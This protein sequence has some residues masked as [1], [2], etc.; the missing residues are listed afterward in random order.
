MRYV[1]LG[2]WAEGPTDHPFLQPLL[3]RLVVEHVLSGQKSVEIS[4]E[5]IRLPDLKPKASRP[6]RICAAVSKCRDEISLLFIHS[7]GKGNPDGARTHV[8][9]PAIAQIASLQSAVHCVA[10]VPVHETE[11]WVLADSGALASAMGVNP[12]SFAPLPAA[13][14]V[15]RYP[16]P[17]QAVLERYQGVSAPWQSPDARLGPAADWRGDSVR[18]ASASSVV[19]SPG[20]RLAGDVESHATAVTGSTNVMAYSPSSR[21]NWSASSSYPYSSAY[22]PQAMAARSVASA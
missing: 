1:T 22:R 4:E 8:V 7:D 17:W 11:A 5:F 18:K 9:N 15:E 16:D 13:G 6:E 3:R 10:V 12:A 2:L 20:G 14:A 19:Q 21:K